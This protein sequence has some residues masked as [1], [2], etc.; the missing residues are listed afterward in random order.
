MAKEIQSYSINFV[1]TVGDT[2]PDEAKIEY[3]VRDTVDTT[4]TKRGSLSV[5][6]SPETVTWA[7]ADSRIKTEE[8]IV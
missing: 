7:D 2:D 1:G 6:T 4:L 8:G 5:T 3:T